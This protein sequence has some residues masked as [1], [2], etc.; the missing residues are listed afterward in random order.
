MDIIIAYDIATRTKDGERR[1]GRVASVCERYGSRV[2]YSLFE[3]RLS[4]SRFIKLQAEL[5]EVIDVNEDCVLLY[6]F[7][8]PLKK[9]K[10]TMGVGSCRDIGTPWII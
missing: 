2:Q 6:R 3:C 8:K 9:V 1:L 5:E 7:E 4:E 10:V